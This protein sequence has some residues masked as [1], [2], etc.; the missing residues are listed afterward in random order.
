MDMTGPDVGGGHA[1]CAGEI[2][3]GD[4]VWWEA[5]S[6]FRKI[7]NYVLGAEAWKTATG[8]VIN[9]MKYVLV[10]N[11]IICSKTIGSGWGDRATWRNLLSHMH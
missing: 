4:E 6:K 10:T 9:N 1:S 2:W 3:A 5:I 7:Q 8:H 11:F